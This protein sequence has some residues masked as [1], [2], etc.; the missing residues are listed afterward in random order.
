MSGD[1]QPICL[2]FWWIWHP[3]ASMDTGHGMHINSQRHTYILT[4]KLFEIIL[5]IQEVFVGFVTLLYRPKLK[6]QDKV[7]KAGFLSYQT[8]AKMCI[9]LSG[10]PGLQWQP[11]FPIRAV[12]TCLIMK[13]PQGFIFSCKNQYAESTY[14]SQTSY[15]PA[16]QS[17]C[18]HFTRKLLWMTFPLLFHCSFL[19]AFLVL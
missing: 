18:L 13:F 16:V 19:Q 11:D 14:A 17:P 8:E 2:Q 3:L 1:S 4:N 10:K 9:Q 12:S 5:K 7:T 15:F 6:H